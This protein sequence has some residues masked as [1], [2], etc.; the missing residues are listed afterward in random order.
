MQASTALFFLCG[1]AANIA[2]VSALENFTPNHPFHQPLTCN[3]DSQSFSA[4]PTMKT[5][6]ITLLVALTTQEMNPNKQRR[7]SQKSPCTKTSRSRSAVCTGHLIQA[8]SSGHSYNIQD[9]WSL[10][11]PQAS[12][13]RRRHRNCS[14]AGP[15]QAFPKK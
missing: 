5:V 15:V 3:T 11:A 2:Y 1:M 13:E 8:G 12:Y 6:A 10:G 4:S 7:S 14:Q 9:R